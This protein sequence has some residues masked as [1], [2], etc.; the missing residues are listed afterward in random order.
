MK[1]TRNT[2]TIDR[3]IRNFRWY[4]RLCDRC[5]K[6]FKGSKASRVCD[7]CLVENCAFR[8]FNRTCVNR[9][10]TYYHISKSHQT[11]SPRPCRLEYC[12]KFKKI[13]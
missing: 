10:N 9:N 2:I 13:K 3:S 7:E 4:S 11:I 8:S 1:I 6:I 12:P 5:G